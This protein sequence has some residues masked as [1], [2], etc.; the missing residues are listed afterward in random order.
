M[1]MTLEEKNKLLN[2]RLKAMDVERLLSPCFADQ[3]LLAHEIG[4][5]PELLSTLGYRP[6]LKYEPLVKYFRSKIPTEACQQ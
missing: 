1:S 2:D 3:V 5:L 6:P 4:L